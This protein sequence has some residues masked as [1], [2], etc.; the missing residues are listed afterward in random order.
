[1]KITWRLLVV[2]LFS[3]WSAASEATPQI[4]LQTRERTQ[5]FTLQDLQAKLPISSMEVEDPVYKTKKTYEGFLLADIFRLMGD[6]P[7]DEISFH[8]R[9]GYSPVVSISMAKEKK[10]LLAIREKG[11]PGGWTKFRQGK[12][13]MTP[14]PFYV[15]WNTSN[16]LFPWP[17][18]VVGIE[19]VQFSQK[20]D[21]IFPTGEPKNGAIFRGFETFK[22]DCLR[23]HS[24]NLQGGDLGPELN[25]PRNITEYR[26]DKILTLFIRDP[27][28]FRARS[29]MP[30]FQQ[31]KDE[32]IQEILE[33][34]RWIKGHKKDPS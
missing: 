11:V 7:G 5:V 3:S 25:I 2:V 24:L 22:N 8:C 34:F 14:A 10:G 4:K 28:S 27:S 33:Y 26:D 19:V 32:Q 30:S 13:W 23:C 17:Y 12:T 21:R 20:F 6:S 18:Q 16:E 9:D 15:V 1:M 29:K 31:L